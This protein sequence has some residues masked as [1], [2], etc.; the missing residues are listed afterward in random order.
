MKLRLIIAIF[1]IL[2]ITSNA[3]TSSFLRAQLR[4]AAYPAGRRV[5]PTLIRTCSTF[6]IQAIADNPKFHKTASDLCNATGA[7]INVLGKDT[8]AIKEFT[9]NFDPTQNLPIPFI[10]D[11]SLKHLEK[12][13]KSVLRAIKNLTQ[14]HADMLAKTQQPKNPAQLL[15]P[16]ED[17]PARP[18]SK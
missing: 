17:N 12:D 7:L 4:G 5:F 6:D 10:H 2:S 15:L 14:A 3:Y 11:G 18:C 9:A 16:S 13:S 1:S 8:K